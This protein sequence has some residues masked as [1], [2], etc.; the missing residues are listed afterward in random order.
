MAILFIM[1]YSAIL[2]SIL[3]LLK[4]FWQFLLGATLIWAVIIGIAILVVIFGIKDTS[5]AFFAI[6]LFGAVP[7]MAIL[8]PV[9]ALIFYF[10]DKAANG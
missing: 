10:I 4:D 9:T 6:I 5:G 3:S 1:I 7:T 8:A 2:I